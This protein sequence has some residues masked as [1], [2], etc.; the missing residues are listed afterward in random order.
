[1]NMIERAWKTGKEYTVVYVSGLIRTYSD[2]V[3]CSV[4][5]FIANSYQ[6]RI[7][8]GTIMYKPQHD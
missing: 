8:D 5:T 2:N 6:Y 3:P 1:M 7:G 4:R